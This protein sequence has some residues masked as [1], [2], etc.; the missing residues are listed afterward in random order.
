MI[1]LDTEPISGLGLS[2][3]SGRR[4]ADVAERRTTAL[5][6]QIAQRD[7]ARRPPLFVKHRQPAHRM[8]PHH[9]DGLLDAVAEGKCQR[10]SA[11]DLSYAC[12]SDVTL[13]GDRPDC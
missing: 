3:A 7:Y 9:L 6:G 4:R 12:G 1:K 13:L 10:L 5:D 11:A 2:S 8:G